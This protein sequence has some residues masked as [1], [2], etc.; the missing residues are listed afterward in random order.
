MFVYAKCTVDQEICFNNSLESD[1]MLLFS[2]SV[3]SSSLPLHGLQHARLPDP[4][5]SPRVCLNSCL[6]S[7][8]SKPT[9]SSSATP[10]CSC[11]ESFPASGSFLL[12]QLFT[13]GGQS[14]GASASASV[15][16]M[17]IQGWFPLGL[18]DWI[19]LLT[20]GPSRVS[21]STTVWK[22]QFFG[23]QPSSWSNSHINTWRLEKP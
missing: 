22:H 16:P 12:S 3:V 6:L 17:N 11:P 21:S 19:S 9:I 5:L 4:S 13:S 8:W 20:K 23:A 1:L 15:L 2:P 10:F 14:I 18:T 7:G